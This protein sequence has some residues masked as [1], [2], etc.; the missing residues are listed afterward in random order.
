V[1]A[2]NSGN[3]NT[4]LWCLERK[5]NKDK[6]NCGTNSVASRYTNQNRATAKSVSK[7][8]TA[9]TDMDKS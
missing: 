5:K 3:L 4:N 7:N 9:T 2:S 1:A 8:A 6:N